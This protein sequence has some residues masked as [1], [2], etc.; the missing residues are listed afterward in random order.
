MINYMITLVY[1]STLLLVL[2]SISIAVASTSS[3]YGF[4]AK[5]L[6]YNYLVTIYIH[7]YYNCLGIKAHVPKKKYLE[8]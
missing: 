7:G 2:N 3:A 4:L 8:R 1:V 5:L 6:L